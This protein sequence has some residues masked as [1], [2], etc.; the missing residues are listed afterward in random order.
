MLTLKSISIDHFKLRETTQKLSRLSYKLSV[1][2][3]FKAWAAICSIYFFV[4]RWNWRKWKYWSLHLMFFLFQGVISV[5]RNAE[6][7]RVSANYI[8]SRLARKKKT[9]FTIY[10]KESCK[11]LTYRDW[12][13]FSPVGVPLNVVVT[14][15]TVWCLKE[16]QVLFVLAH[17]VRSI[18]GPI[19]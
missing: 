10:F 11:I 2:H 19:A 15:L 6:W 4:K 18:F 14:S 8:R 7:I 1:H 12:C 16:C 9:P 13:F 5:I 3:Y 17:P